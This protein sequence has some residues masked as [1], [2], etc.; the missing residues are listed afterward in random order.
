[1]KN[2]KK[3]TRETMK[4]MIGGAGPFQEA[5]ADVESGGQWCHFH[6]TGSLWGSN[7][8]ITQEHGG[9]CPKGSSQCYSYFASGS[10]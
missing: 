8:K 3:V 10:C 6:Y 7:M 4:K 1:M 2:L 5:I 9:S